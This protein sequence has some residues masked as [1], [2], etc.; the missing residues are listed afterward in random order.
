MTSPEK[1]KRHKGY[2]KPDYKEVRPRF[3]KDWKKEVFDDLTPD[4][5]DLSTLKV[6]TK[7]D[8]GV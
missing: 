7:V 1:K 3:N 6:G 4:I 5:S 8:Y 2:N